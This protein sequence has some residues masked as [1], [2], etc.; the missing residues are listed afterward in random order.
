MKKTGNI[1]NLDS[2]EREIRRLSLET[3][4]MEKKIVDNIENLGEEAGSMFLNSISCRKSD[5][6]KGDHRQDQSFFRNEKL[7]SIA[8]KI[9]DRIADRVADGIGH[10]LD[11]I[12]KKEKHNSH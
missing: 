2:I 4:R 3:H 6:S 1:H 10:L 8:S 5:S 12:F 11:R 9:T 7:N